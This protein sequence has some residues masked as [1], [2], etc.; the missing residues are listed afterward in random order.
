LNFAFIH[1]LAMV[2]KATSGID[3]LAGHVLCAMLYA[4]LPRAPV[5]SHRHRATPQDA[6]A[7][8]VR[9]EHMN[10]LDAKI[11]QSAPPDQ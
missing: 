5:D 9:V 10:E 1:T 3:R 11:A 2:M 7:E 6:E 4:L 8:M